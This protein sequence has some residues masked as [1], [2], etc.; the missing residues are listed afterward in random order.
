LQTLETLKIERD[1]G[2]QWF[3]SLDSCQQTRLA[4]LLDS[5]DRNEMNLVAH[6]ENSLNLLLSITLSLEQQ[7]RW[8]N[9]GQPDALSRDRV[10]L[11]LK[12]LGPAA[13]DAIKNLDHPHPEER[14][15][16]SP[17]AEQRDAYSH[18]LQ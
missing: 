5:V 14:F 1:I 9:H 12:E 16:I 6:P 17:S 11:L 2:S 10:A 18:V 8:S 3:A 4:H 7:S 15:L 13:A